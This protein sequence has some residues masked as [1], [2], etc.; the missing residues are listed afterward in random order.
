M[1]PYYTNIFSDGFMQ[2]IDGSNLWEIDVHS[3]HGENWIAK[4]DWQKGGK[5]LIHSLKH[6]KY[7]YLQSLKHPCRIS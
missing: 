1:M 7:N 3:T 5:G 4:K 2:G 6:C